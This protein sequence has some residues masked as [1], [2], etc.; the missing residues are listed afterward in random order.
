MVLSFEKRAT[1]LQGPLARSPTRGASVPSAPAWRSQWR[2]FRRAWRTELERVFPHERQLMLAQSRAS[3]LVLEFLAN[4]GALECG[5][6]VLPLLFAVLVARSSLGS[7]GFEFFDQC[8]HE[9]RTVVVTLVC[10]PL[11][12]W[13]R[14]CVL[15]RHPFSRHLADHALSRVHQSSDVSLGA[16]RM[17]APVLGHHPLTRSCH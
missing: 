6:G 3:C 13:G 8:P 2:P 7:I 17:W 1:I 12:S 11:S 9:R 4:L 14:Q 10:R 16:K 5:L 15:T